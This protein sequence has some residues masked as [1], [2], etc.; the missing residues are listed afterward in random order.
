[1]PIHRLPLQIGQPIATKV[2]YIRLPDL[3]VSVVEQDYTRLTEG[4]MPARFRY[5]NL[6]SGF[7]AELSV[8]ADG[9]VVDYGT[10]WRRRLGERKGS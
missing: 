2:V 8:D 9:I 1:M 5:R 3:A 10:I 7:S 6:G 4:E